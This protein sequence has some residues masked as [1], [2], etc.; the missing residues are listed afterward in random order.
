MRAIQALAML[1]AERWEVARIK[2]SHRTL[3][4]DGLTR[5]FSYHLRVEL[6][7]TQMRMLR[8]TFGLKPKGEK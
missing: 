1:E 5:R 2:G 6:G 8:K 3:K 4:R 7:A